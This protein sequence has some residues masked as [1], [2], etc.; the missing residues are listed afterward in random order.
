VWG[1]GGGGPVLCCYQSSHSN[2]QCQKNARFKNAISG[3]IMEQVARTFQ[4]KY[5]QICFEMPERY[6]LFKKYIQIQIGYYT[7]LH[8]NKSSISKILYQLSIR[9]YSSETYDGF[10]QCF[11]CFGF[12]FNDSGSGSSI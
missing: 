9:R 7:V 12:G 4:V 1:G 6:L 5:V 8:G 3:H 2:W 10:Q 11:H